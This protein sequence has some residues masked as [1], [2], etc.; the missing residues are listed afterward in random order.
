MLQQGW[1]SVSNPLGFSCYPSLTVSWVKS[2]AAATSFS[3]ECWYREGSFDSFTLQG[4]G[5]TSPSQGGHAPSNQS[6]RG[7]FK[8]NPGAGNRELRKRTLAEL[9][10]PVQSPVSLPLSR[11]EVALHW[12]VLPVP[13]AS[14]D[15][16]ASM[17]WIRFSGEGAQPSPQN[18]SNYRHALTRG[19]S[20]FHL[21][22]FTAQDV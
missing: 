16:G 9:G 3:L 1:R 22:Q 21:L 18:P 15:G 14:A 19:P 13:L 6:P 17:F 4:E 7:F 11:W 12:T 5:V 8:K 2:D 10:V 20:F